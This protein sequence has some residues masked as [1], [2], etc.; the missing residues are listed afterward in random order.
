MVRTTLPKLDKV[1]TSSAEVHMAQALVVRPGSKAP[2]DDFIDDGPGHLKFA[3]TGSETICRMS[4]DYRCVGLTQGHRTIWFGILDG[5]VFVT[6]DAGPG[7]N[8]GNWT[9]WFGI[10]DGPVFVTPDA[11]PSF[12]VLSHE[13]VKGGLLTFLRLAPPSFFYHWPPFGLF[14][15]IILGGYSSPRM[16]SLPLVD[17]A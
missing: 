12:L 3:A 1:G 16:M 6:P 17:S 15:L 2:D 8:Q 4:P 11:G 9:V 13:N 5:P 7:L 14:G 10:P